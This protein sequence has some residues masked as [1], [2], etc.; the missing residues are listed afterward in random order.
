M[1]EVNLLNFLKDKI[2]GVDILTEMQAKTA[3]KTYILIEKVGSSRSDHIEYPIVN[4]KSVSTT[5]AK[6][7]ALNEQ[8]KQALETLEGYEGIASATINSD[9]SDTNTATKEYRYCTVF[10]FTYYTNY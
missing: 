4:F 10:Q 2:D 3:P 9:Y 8:V 1:I 7:A 5:M 6:A